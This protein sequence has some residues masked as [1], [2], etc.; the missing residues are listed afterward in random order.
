MCVCVSEAPPP[1][2]LAYDVLSNDAVMLTEHVFSVC[3]V[4]AQVGVFG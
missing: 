4:T 2:S 1:P 3:S